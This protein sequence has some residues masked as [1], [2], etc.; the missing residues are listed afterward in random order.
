MGDISLL[1]DGYVHTM[2]RTLETN[3][4][5]VDLEFPEEREI[6]GFSIIVGSA[7]V[8]IR[9]SVAPEEGTAREFSTRYRGSVDEPE[10]TLEFGK[11]LRAKTLRIDITDLRNQEPAHVHAWEIDFH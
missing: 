11:P 3:P 4:L 8:E 6:G 2:L 9:A 7:N 5:T 1:F 10:V